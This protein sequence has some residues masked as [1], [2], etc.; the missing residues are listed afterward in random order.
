[1]T[2]V[3][4]VLYGTG[5]A[6]VTPFDANGQ[7]DFVALHKLLAFTAE[8]VD[9]WVVNGTTGESPVLSKEE[10]KKLL[11]F[12][13]ENNPKKL[14][15]VWGMGGNHTQEL[16]AQI[17]ET[18]LSGVAA[19]LSVSPYYNKPSQEGIFRHY[20]AVADACP[21]PVLLYNV[22]GRTGSNISGATTVRLAAHPNIIGTKDASGDF[23][24]YTYIAK[25]APEGFLL[26]SGDDMLTVP[27]IAIGGKGVI[28][29][30]ANAFPVSFAQMTRAALQGNFAE[31]AQMMYSF[32]N[33]NG[34]L[35]KEGNPTGIKY[36]LSRL[37]ICE[38]H[39]RLPN[40][41]PSEELSNKLDAALAAITAETQQLVGA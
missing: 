19:V 10:R 36:V 20:T 5:V 40:V 17:K 24:Q 13:K 39:L 28:S 9:Y 34:L 26:I 30:L 2:D 32:A 38:P 23:E 27:L 11:A 31:A 7:I 8:G 21:V 41:L 16:V 4:T 1:M 14:P 12:V 6:L 33:I 3:T 35:Y 22:P 25:N 37:G 18:D 29:V 15:I